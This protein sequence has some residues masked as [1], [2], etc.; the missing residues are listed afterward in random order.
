[1]LIYHDPPPSYQVD[2]HVWNSERWGSEDWEAARKSN[3]RQLSIWEQNNAIVFD[4]PELINHTRVALAPLRSESKDVIYFENTKTNVLKRSLKQGF[5][6]GFKRGAKHGFKKD[7]MTTL[8]RNLKCNKETD[9][10]DH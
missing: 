3:T 9:S 8:K 5:K 4:L 1:M 7:F 10:V 2:H 6:S